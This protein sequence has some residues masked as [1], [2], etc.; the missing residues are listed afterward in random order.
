MSLSTTARRLFSSLTH[1][2][3]R[4]RGAPAYDLAIIGTGIVGLATARELLHRYQHSH[5]N[6]NN[7]RNRPRHN[8]KPPLSLCLLEKEH[9]IGL[10]Q[11]KRNSGVLH[12]GIYYKP[13]SKQ[14]HHCVNGARLLS[15][16]CIQHALP[17]KRVGKLIVAVNH[18]EVER[19]H[20]LFERGCDN[21]V[22]DLKLIEKN[23]KICALEPNISAEQA[24]WSPS[25][26]I[27]DFH[28]IAQHFARSITSGCSNGGHDGIASA[29][30]V[31][32]IHRNFEVV[33]IGKPMLFSDTDGTIQSQSH[34]HSQSQSQSRATYNNQSQLP[35]L[36][37]TL[38]SAANQTVYA[39]NIVTC[40]GL[41]SDRIA[42]L[43][44]GHDTPK[45]I[46][47]RG[48]FLKVRS[49]SS[50]GGRNPLVR[51]NVYPTP[52]PEL[53]FLEV[54]ITP[55]ISGLFVVYVVCMFV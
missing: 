10:H 44:G 53:P 45:L 30:P 41:H 9:D 48:K 52:N 26:A 7:S 16:Y 36:Y 5:N 47:F 32:D 23:Q 51:A 29:V 4:I 17:Y 42:K 2:S 55:T 24:I 40:A 1:V 14:A 38:V 33:R 18:K 19:L 13:G 8:H 6:N 49:S 39:R 34:S 37:H 54:H 27:V 3:H 28:A 31:A 22:P 25:T 43:A 50:L 15:L 35:T 12:S 11:T 46:A 20:K 21:G